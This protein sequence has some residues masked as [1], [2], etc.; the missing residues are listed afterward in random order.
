MGDTWSLSETRRTPDITPIL[1]TIKGSD[2]QTSSNVVFLFKSDYDLSTAARRVTAF[3]RTEYKPARLVARVGQIPKAAVS[4]YWQ[5]AD[6]T[7]KPPSPWSC[8]LRGCTKKLL[9][10]FDR[11]G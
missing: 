1:A 2:W 11:R 8:T 4:Y 5:S 7:T 10:N 9:E 6:C 3:E